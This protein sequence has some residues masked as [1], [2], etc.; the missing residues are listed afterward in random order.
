[1]FLEKEKDILSGKFDKSLIKL[2]PGEGIMK[3]IYDISFFQIYSNKSVLQVEAAGFQVLPGLLY[4]F[5]NAIKNNEKE[6]SK[7][8]LNILPD[9][10]IF[11]YKKEPYNAI[12]GALTYVAG[13]T[14][15]FA[16]DTYRNLKG[17]QLPN[18]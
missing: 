10:Y 15:Q 9:E 6:S 11:D 8:I 18:Y 16:V 5:L 2:I 3:E 4:I 7:K 17:I 14:D 1:M 13:M 12:M